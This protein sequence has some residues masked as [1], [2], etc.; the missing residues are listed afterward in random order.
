[1][2]KIFF[3]SFIL[4][5]SSFYAQI[6]AKLEEN[7]FKVNIL[8]PGISFEKAISTNSTINI[9]LGTS[10]GY[11]ANNNYSGFLIGPCAIAQYRFYYNLENRL[12]KRKNISG[13][14][15]AYLALNSSYYG[16]AFNNKNYI[17]FLDG[18]TVGGVLG[19]QKTYKF[20]LNLGANAGIGYNFSEN[21][22]KKAVPILNF[23]VG[24]VIFK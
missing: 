6:G 4:S 5:F 15:G 3:L 13:N 10:I 24:W 20:G 21:Q 7:M 19:F 18:L 23:T 11:V 9:E 12:K 22:P 16:Q 17:N 1:M 8:T 2:K 14:S